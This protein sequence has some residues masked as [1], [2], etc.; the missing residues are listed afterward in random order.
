[1]GDTIR[2]FF[3]IQK[4]FWLGHKKIEYGNK[5]PNKVSKK[6]R[7]EDIANKIIKLYE[8][9]DKNNNLPDKLKETD[10]FL[11]KYS[12][13][14]EMV[15]FMID[16]KKFLENEIKNEN[17]E[18]NDELEVINQ[19]KLQYERDL[20]FYNEEKTSIESDI[21]KYELFFKLNLDDILNYIIELGIDSD[22]K[23]VIPKKK[24]KILTNLFRILKKYLK[25]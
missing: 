7:Y 22:V 21:E 1:M 24:G 8:T 16:L 15:L 6:F 19:I 12:Q 11:K 18:L 14:E 4:Y 9:E 10:I 17:K 23:E 5:I 13:M 2:L 20:K 25:L 3:E